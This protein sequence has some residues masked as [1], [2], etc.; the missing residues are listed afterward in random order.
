[1]PPL[2]VRLGVVFGLVLLFHGF[3]P[4]AAAEIPAD[5]PRYDLDV[6]LDTTRHV[7]LV[8]QRITW[9]NQH[10]RPARE[11]VFNVHARY[12]VPAAD[13]GS[14]AKTLEM[15]RLTPR[16]AL[17]LR[18]RACEITRVTLLGWVGT[19]D[20]PSAPPPVSQGPAELAFR[21][22]D[23]NQTALEVPLPRSVGPGESV[24]IAVTFA[25]RL[26][27]KQGRWGHWRGV[28]FLSNWLPVLAYYDDQGWQPVPFIPW[29]QPFFNEAGRYHVRL[30]LPADQGVAATAAILSTEDSPDGWRRVEFAP[31]CARDFALLCSARYREFSAQEGPVRVKVYAFPEHEH[32]AR[33]MLRVAGEAIST[34]SRWFG[35]YPYP[36]FTIAESYFGWNGNECSGLVMID[37]RV[38]AMPHLAEAYVD[39]LVSHEVCHQW[40]YNVVGTN[41]HAETWMDEALATYFSHR[42]QD[43]KRGR[44]NSL[45]R[46]PTG[47]AWL[48]GIH[49]ATYASVGMYGALGRGEL[50]PAVQEMDRYGHLV[51]L[52]SACYDKGSRV[53]GM[54]ENRL[55]EAAFLDFMRIIYARYYFRIV[56]V[57]DLQRELEAYTGRSWDEF[58]RQWVYGSGWTDWCVEQVTV[59][60]AAPGAG[61]ARPCRVTVL[62]RQQ[63]EYDEPTVL[64]FCFPGTTGYA[65]RLPVVPGVPV[66][67]TDEP[68]ARVEMLPEHGVRIVVLLP[69]RPTQVTVDPDRVLLDRDPANNSW[70]PE[71]RWRFTPLY[72]PLEETDLTNDHDRWNV[73]AGPWVYGASYADSW[74]TRSPLA[75]LRAGTYRTQQF[76]GGA[77][78]AY[79]TDFRDLVAGVDG[80]WDHW[81]WP[82]TQVGFHAERSL[83]DPWGGDRPG[84]CDRAVL[85]GRYVFQYGSAMYLPPLHYLEAFGTFQDNGLPLAPPVVAGAERPD[86]TAAVGLHYHLDYRTPYWD[87]EG[88]FRLDTTVAAGMA[89]FRC[90]Q[91]FQRF[92]GD[93]SFVRRLPEGLG[94]L[95]ETRLAARLLGSAA[96][97]DKGQFVALGGSAF[98]GF[99]L[100]R[101]QGSLL[102]SASLEWRVPLAQG[103]TWDWADHVAGVRNVH[104]ATFYDVGA[105]YADGGS[106][107]GVA[108]ALGTGLC[109]DVA[110][111]SFVERTLLRFDVA[112][113]VNAAT[114]V[115]FW[116][117]IQHPF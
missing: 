87:P 94:Q 90:R 13:T 12:Q 95:S 89:D 85:F 73:L 41:G 27:E 59:E 45:V 74:Y 48:P 75:G 72:T 11:L 47:L 39:Y 54:I 67:E 8:Q 51:N 7:A 77:Y 111:F 24:A 96:L 2:R 107:G 82:R 36:E 69:D 86:R 114:P 16:E 21:F 15:L 31:C 117:G 23:D 62:L 56:R 78:A 104:V 101:R 50:G 9:T 5:L 80:L 109:V 33:V 103:L 84:D 55:G 112:K 116:F 97:P 3:A 83:T 65:V 38:F 20:T 91:H 17:D 66:L 81:P 113:A 88:G 71:I 28:T 4:T 6:H 10:R 93:V 42:L 1:M 44:N 70:K 110:W 64:G 34:Y 29:H 100:A 108:H 57:T 52:F 40:W 102:W 99:D 35:P 49:R 25:V 19:Q 106:V 26:P 60:A 37:E 22:R 61:S 43:R 14:L 76:S 98:R 68:P 32:Y 58:F 46:W 92:D 105:V 18:G 30:T 79:R 115:Q 63:A 53:V